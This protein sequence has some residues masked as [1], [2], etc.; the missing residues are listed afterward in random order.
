M[1]PKRIPNQIDDPAILMFWSQ[2]E[3]IP[4]VVVLTFGFFSGWLTTSFLAA[5]LAL[6]AFRRL[7]DGNPR[8]YFFHWFWWIGIGGAKKAR[9]IHNPFVREFRP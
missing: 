8:G 4:I 6:K 7:R 2:D 9:T 3:F 5:W 1:E